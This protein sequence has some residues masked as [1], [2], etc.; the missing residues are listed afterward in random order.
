MISAYAAVV[1]TGAAAWNIYV[2]RRDRSHL[3]LDLRF[4]RYV[5]D[6]R[7]GEQIEIAAGSERGFLRLE[8][9]VSNTGRRPITVCSW[10]ARSRRGAHRDL[11]IDTDKHLVP[12]SDRYSTFASGELIDLLDKPHAQM[13]NVRDGLEAGFSAMWVTDSAGRKWKVPRKTLR[14]IEHEYKEHRKHPA[15]VVTTSHVP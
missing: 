5:Q 9:T 1:A 6:S 15:I 4:R 8:L 11:V 3:S 2:A 13:S 12:E 10:E 7:S 14:R